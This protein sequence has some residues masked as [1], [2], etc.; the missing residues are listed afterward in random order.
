[1][2]WHFSRALVAEFSEES[3]SGGVACA[4]SSLTDTRENASFDAKTTEPSLR[5]RYGT[6]YEPLTVDRGE[7]LLKSFQAA[8]RVKTFRRRAKGRGSRANGRAFGAKWREL[9]VRFDRPSCSWRTHRFLWDEERSPSSVI[10]PKWGLMRRGVLSALITSERLTS[11]TDFG[12]WVGTPTASMKIS[13][14]DFAQGRTPNPAEAAELW[15][16]PTV[17]GNYNRKGCSERSGD[18][19]E[20]AVRKRW[21]TPSASDSTR[22]ERLTSR[23]SGVSLAQQINTPSAWP[24][25]KAS[26]GSKGGPS[27]RFGNGSPTLPAMAARWPT[28]AASDSNKW[29]N[30]TAEERR[31]KGQYARL[32][33]AVGAGGSLNPTWVEWLMGWPLGWTALEP[34]EMDRFREWFERSS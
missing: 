10:L 12:C 31:A 15:P 33:N 7:A 11:A 21:A 28:P 22:G 8:F 14:A 23:M 16:T 19:L 32:P 17:N 20:T 6:T 5:S 29:N 34:L 2:S 4:R 25:P 3:S 26:D 1:M 30:Q 18:G 24:T 9:S 13:S 27:Q